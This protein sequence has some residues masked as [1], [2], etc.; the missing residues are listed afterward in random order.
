MPR[1]IQDPETGKLIPASEYV[2][3]SNRSAFIRA[4]IGPFVSPIDKKVIGG[5]K[6]L[7]EHN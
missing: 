5:R 1:W 4:D 3:P 2:P 7:R 6:Q